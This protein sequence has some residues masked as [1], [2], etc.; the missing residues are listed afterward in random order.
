MVTNALSQTNTDRDPPW[1]LYRQN[2]HGT[3]LDLLGVPARKIEACMTHDAH[4]YFA[5][6]EDMQAAYQIL[7]KTVVDELPLFHVEMNKHDPK[8][9]FFM[10]K[11]TGVADQKSS[12]KSGKMTFLFLDYFS[13]IVQRTGKHNGAGTVFSNLQQLPKKIQNHELGQILSSI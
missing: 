9:L 2:N 11:F 5:T 3:V 1:I 7:T 6:T 8:K 10:I 4:L 12:V 13:A